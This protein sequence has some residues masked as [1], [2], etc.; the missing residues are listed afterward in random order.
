MT[1]STVKCPLANEIYPGSQQRQGV[2]VGFVCLGRKA[3]GRA[4]MEAHA[5]SAGA[6][7]VINFRVG[8]AGNQFF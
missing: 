7:P 3:Q 6:R 5:E 4:G 1:N 8:G 2:T